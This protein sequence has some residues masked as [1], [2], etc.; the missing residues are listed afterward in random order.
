MNLEDRREL[1]RLIDEE[2]F[3]YELNPDWE[4]VTNIK[5]VEAARRLVEPDYE[6]AHDTYLALTG[7]AFTVAIAKAVDAALGLVDDDS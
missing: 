2:T 6:A 4:V 5:V 7:S 3:P 1:L